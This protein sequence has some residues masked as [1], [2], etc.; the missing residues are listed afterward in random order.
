MIPLLM[1]RSSGSAGGSAAVCR[2]CSPS[3]SSSIF[4][5]PISAA[6]ASIGERQRLQFFET[7]A[8]SAICRMR[9]SA[10]MSDDAP[11]G[12]EGRLH[13]AL[14]PS[15]NP[16]HVVAGKEDA[17]FVGRHVALH[18][19][20]VHPVVIAIVAGERPLEGAEEIGVGL[21]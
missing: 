18:E 17:A 13:R 14:D 11:H 19:L 8:G 7:I 6:E 9:F 15:R 3:S 1:I 16:R 10:E 5:T 21:P 20:A 2:C 12:I 4:G